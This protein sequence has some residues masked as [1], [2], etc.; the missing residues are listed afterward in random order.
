MSRSSGFVDSLPPLQV[1]HAVLLLAEHQTRAAGAAAVL[2][3][4]DAA[5]ARP[6]G[7]V[8]RQ[9]VA[10]A[11][12]HDVSGGQPAVLPAGGPLVWTCTPPRFQ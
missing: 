7:P 1:Q 8:R 2:G 9:Q 5:Q 12:A 10:A 3:P 11:I 6:G 4:A